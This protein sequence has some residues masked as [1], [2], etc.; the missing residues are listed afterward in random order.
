MASSRT[1]I[2]AAIAGNGALAVTKFIAAGLTGSSAMLAEGIHS[3][4]DTG[5]GG[6][7]LL[8]IRRSKRPADAEHPY[9][10]GKE[11]YFWTLIVAIL[12]FGVGGGISIYEGVLHVLHPGPLEMETYTFVGITLAGPT[13]NYI[14]LGL[15]VIFEG[16]AW[17]A[18][19]RAFSHLKGEKPYW[20]AV[21]ESKDPTTFAVLFEDSAALAGLI[22]AALGIFLTH[23]LGMPVL[24][25]VASIT[26]GVILCVVATLLIYEAKDLLLGE[27][28]D[29]A[30]RADIR[31]LAAQDE[32]VENVVRILS[33]HL[34]P[35]DVLLTIDLEFRDE[36]S[37]DDL[38][39]VIDRIE[40]SIRDEHSDVTHIFIEAEPRTGGTAD[41]RRPTTAA[42]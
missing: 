15:G 4:V 20:Q 9:G 13:L 14:V 10:Y 28:V 17:I 37:A 36:L 18:A 24:D 27:S 29:P 21:R 42:S 7:L 33:M 40:R 41:D 35:H 5:N 11:L 23:Q 8:G 32:A 26:I 31:R 22:V 25:G 34:G 19:L 1:A 2:Y 12:I 30:V 38:E 16:Q 6:L 3:L 39:A